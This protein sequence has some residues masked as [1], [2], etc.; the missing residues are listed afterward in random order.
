MLL[1]KYIRGLRWSLSYILNCDTPIMFSIRYSPKT[2]ILDCFN[3]V[4]GNYLFWHIT[5]ITLVMG[6]IIRHWET[7]W[8]IKNLFMPNFSRCGTRTRKCVRSNQL[9]NNRLKNNKCA[10][11]SIFLIKIMC[12][13]ISRFTIFHWTRYLRLITGYFWWEIS[14]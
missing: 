14:G 2:K 4:V 5:K 1:V 12:K 10:L 9:N 11:Y 6:I 8:P 3:P 7:Q 13:W